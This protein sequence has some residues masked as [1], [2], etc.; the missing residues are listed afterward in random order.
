MRE[1]HPEIAMK[2]VLKVYI[3]GAQALG[4][5]SATSTVRNFPKP[6]RGIKMLFTKPP[7]DELFWN[8]IFHAGTVGAAAEK[9]APKV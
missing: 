5:L 3:V 2:L 6:P 4:I 8:P 7:T 9:A 1:N